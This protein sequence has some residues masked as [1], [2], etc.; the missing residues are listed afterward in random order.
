MIVNGQSY[1]V[2][3]HVCQYDSGLEWR[4]C[5]INFK[6]IDYGEDTQHWE[7]QITIQEDGLPDAAKTQA[8]WSYLHNAIDQKVQITFDKEKP[9]GPEFRY[10]NPLTCFVKDVGEVITNDGVTAELTFTIGAVLIDSY[11][12]AIP[13]W[14]YETS[15]YPNYE[16]LKRNWNR[17]ASYEMMVSNFTGYDHGDATSSMVANI[18][19]TGTSEV[20]RIFRK[21]LY[22]Q[23][24]DT[25]IYRNYPIFI[26]PGV[27]GSLNVKCI[28]FGPI[29]PLDKACTRWRFSI[30]LVRIA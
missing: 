4:Q 20:V 2:V 14:D 7:A 9:F 16:G 24:G 19:Y 3:S 12:P 29:E 18:V 26:F 22:G 28:D 23:R 11:Y 15:E 1:S 6:A 25:F 21:F 30:S 17:N 27:A 13:S 5:G 10:D 8:L